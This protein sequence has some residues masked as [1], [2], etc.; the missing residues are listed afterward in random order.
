MTTQ[1]FASTIYFAALFIRLQVAFPEK[2]FKYP[3]LSQVQMSTRLF[4]FQKQ[5]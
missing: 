4:S 1:T 2:P 5:V 3:P